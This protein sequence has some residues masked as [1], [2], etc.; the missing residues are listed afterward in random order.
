[1]H[2]LDADVLIIGAGIQGVGVAQAVQAAGYDALVLEQ[3]EAAAG[4]SSRSSKL[5]HGGLRYLENGELRLVRESLRERE[6]LLRIAPHL[7]RLVPFHI[8]IY[9]RTT[10]RPWQIRL[11]LTLYAMLA[12]MHPDS[13]FRSLP[14]RDW[15]G[16]DG[17]R[18][19]GLQRVFRYRD[20]Q[21]DDAA[22]CRAVLAS[23]REL[24]CRYEERAPLLQADRAPEGWLVRYRQND[25]EH[26]VRAR[27]LVNAAGPWVEGVLARIEAPGPTRSV[28]LVAGTHIVCDGTLQQGIYYAEAPADR[29]AVLVMPYQSRILLGTTEKLFKGEP[30]SVKPSE[31]EIAYLLEVARHYFPTRE[32]KVRRAF[33]GLRVLPSA[34]TTAFQRKR[35][36]MLVPDDP[37]CPRL[38]TIY[39]GKLTAYRR[40]AEK[41]MRHIR[42]GLARSAAPRADTSTL[43]LPE[44]VSRGQPVR[45]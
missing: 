42:R 40:T 39:G 15:D 5:I 45:S 21:T 20:G 10:R 4:T 14:R 8:P 25:R 32:F 18:R 16:L 29:R 31:E 19:D 28:D 36:V 9:R 12:G 6:I 13:R 1:M 3:S 17:L 35:E 44:L 27:M 34:A 33:A 24:G 23:A 43:R 30:G 11:G 26:R 37:R 22:L 38:T 7:V 2:D 41:A